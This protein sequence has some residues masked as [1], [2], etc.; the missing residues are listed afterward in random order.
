MTEIEKLKRDGAFAALV[1]KFEE[2]GD[3]LGG[4]WECMTLNGYEKGKDE[5]KSTL[6]QLDLIVAEIKLLEEKE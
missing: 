3:E 1:A 2:L 4:K 5:T 6:D